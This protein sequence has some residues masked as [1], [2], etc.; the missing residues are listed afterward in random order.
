MPTVTTGTPTATI[1]TS[2]RTQARWSSG[3]TPSTTI[4][5]PDADGDGWAADCAPMDPT[6]HPDA[7]EVYCDGV[8]QDC[9]AGDCCTNDGDGDGDGFVCRADCNDQAASVYPGR[10]LTPGMC[11]SADVNCNG[12]DDEEPCL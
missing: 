4:A 6:V 7:P 3:A 12:I 5:D 9:E 2:A 8:D 1:T 10:P 11:Y